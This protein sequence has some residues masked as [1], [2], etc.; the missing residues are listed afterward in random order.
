M[1]NRFIIFNLLILYAWVGH[2]QMLVEDCANGLD[3]DGDGLIDLNDPDCKC[4]GIKDTIFVPSSLIPN[5]SFED[6][7][8]CPTGLAQIDTFHI[9]NWIQAS[10][11]TSDYY[12]T[13]GFKD[14]PTMRGYPPQPLPAGNGYVGFLD[15][16]DR[17]G[18]NTTYKEYV[19]A[20]LTSSMLPGKDY[21]LSFWI[22]FG[23]PGGFW[24]PRAITTL[25]IFGTS[26]CSNLPFGNGGWSCPTA[27]PGWFLLTS[28]TA[29]GTNKWVKVKVK[30][31]PTR[32]VEA[33]VVGP[34]CPR[35]DGYYYFWCDDFILEESAKFDSIYLSVQGNPCIDSIQLSS[36]PTK[37]SRINYQ[38][39]FNGIAINGA[40]MQNYLIP[41]GQV[42]KY[43]LKAIDGADCELSNTFN[44]TIDSLTSDIKQ[45]I[46]KGEIFKVGDNFF[47]KSGNYR[48]VIPSANGCDSIVHLNLIVNTPGQG[49][50]DTT[51]CENEFLDINGILYDSSG[52]Y[53]VLS[54]TAQGCDSLSILN[55]TVNKIYD[56]PINVSICEGEHYIVGQDT[57]YV[58]GDY[59]LHYS[60]IASCDSVVTI[61]LVVNKDVSQKI[62]TAICQGQNIQAGNLT[63]DQTGLY[64]LNLTSKDGC[65]S[66]VN[67]NLL[68]NPVYFKAID[69]SFCEGN[70]MIFGSQIYNQTGI[71]NLNLKTVEGCDSNMQLK[72]NVFPVH[73]FNFDK[74]ICKGQSYLFA[75][76][77]FDSSGIYQVDLL[78]A[79]GCDSTLILNLKVLDKYDVNLD[80]AICDNLSIRIGNSDY[81][82]AGNYTQQLTSIGGCD[83]ILHINLGNYKSYQ[84]L[85]DTSVC[86]GYSVQI[87]SQYYSSQGMYQIGLKTSKGCDSLITMNLKVKPV[88]NSRLDTV[89]C[90]DGQILI[91]GKVY[92]DESDF[93]LKYTTVNGCDSTLAVRIR[94]TKRPEVTIESKSLLCFGDKSGAIKLKVNGTNGPYKYNWSNGQN[95]ADLNQLAAGNYKVSITDSYNC[96]VEQD[97]E[98]VSPEKLIFL[99][100]VKNAS[101]MDPLKG[102][103]LIKAINGG[104]P[105]YSY[106]LDGRVVSF[107]SLKEFAEVG[108][109]EVTVKDSNGC[110]VSYQLNI[111]PA[112]RG[113]INLQPDSL[114][115]ILGDSVYLE[116]FLNNIDSIANVNWSGPGYISCKN[117]LSTSVFINSFGGDFKVVI[118]D[119]NGCIYEESIYVKSKQNFYVPNVFSPN[120][121]NIN[122]FFNLITDRSIDNI[123]ELHIYDR[124]GNQLYER[125]NFPPNGVE[126]A[127]NGE[128]NSQK[129]LPG[130]YV[131]LFVF[132]DKA[133]IN[134]QLSGNLT[135]IR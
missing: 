22:G 125:K 2:G 97:V 13:C 39:Y 76:K 109:H 45:Q 91:D 62:D 107:T 48:V 123:E 85:I 106:L 112:R 23:K 103:I 132:K 25:S 135:L 51:I 79:F 1:I 8:L 114:S 53:Q 101:C 9:K 14:D 16:K 126:G 10:S 24:G 78:N 121:D 119:N 113:D 72:L 84:S 75:G 80:T 67:V 18:T 128:A 102:D 130:V 31:R 134:H 57:F 34:A 105:P 26:V 64:S 133:G 12:N 69:T 98:I 115:V 63:L 33:I 116:V 42:G 59:Q 43:V 4:K 83:S 7:K 54:K 61:H 117:C 36:P 38:W 129:A 70:Q 27:Y 88:F 71:Y 47:T 118:T 90:F 127:W 35:A 99:L 93:Y 21:T 100:D 122:D 120:G 49:A 82:V 44:Y 81:T 41:K 104:K 124:W 58:S 86:Q 56:T 5:P 108:A 32:T 50:L 40:T 66:I 68:V 20:C 6:Y 37:I 29:S 77:N 30:I 73:Q 87:G 131:Y 65:D 28:V 11:A 111:D 17:P 74:S 15:L 46:C 94:K 96:M 110:E 89:I 60:S 19:G 3:D 52:V 92:S 55:L 95:T